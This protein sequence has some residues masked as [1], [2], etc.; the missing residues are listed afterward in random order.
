MTKLREPVTIENTLYR[1]LGELTI[2][3]AAEATGRAVS[4]LRALTDPDK[5]EQLTV[6]DLELLDLACHEKLGQGFPLFEALG[7]RL[8][9]ARADRFAGA[10]CIG[11]HAVEV[12]KENGEAVAALLEAALSAGDPRLLEEALRQSE[13]VHRV[14]TAT[15]ATIRDQLSRS[16]L[17]PPQAEPP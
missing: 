7:R 16:R 6:R 13:D 5:R 12:A 8:E 17:V 3:R 1:V 2:E 4:Y 10:A 14:V 11:R 9:T 15:I